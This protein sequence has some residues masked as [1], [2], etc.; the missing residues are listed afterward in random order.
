MNIKR[1]QHAAL[2]IL[3]SQTVINE[4][5]MQLPDRDFVNAGVAEEDFE[6]AE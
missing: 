4:T 5:V 1:F 6:G 3:C 2:R